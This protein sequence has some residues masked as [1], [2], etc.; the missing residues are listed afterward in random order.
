MKLLTP[1]DAHVIMGKLVRM[2]TGQSSVEVVDTSSFVSAGQL[3]LETGMENVYNNFN[4]LMGM[5][6]IATRKYN[7]DLTL[8]DSINSGVFTHRFEKVS[9]YSLDP[10]ASGN[11]NT[12]L[13]INLADGFTAGQNP[14]GHGDPQSTKSQWEQSQ[15]PFAVFNY[16]ISDVWDFCV[17]MYD[18]QVQQAFRNENEFNRFI[19]GYLTEHA[20]DIESQREAFNRMVLL[21]KIG[22][23]YDMSTSMPGSVVNLTKKY[24][25]KF[26]TSFTSAELRSTY[27]K[28]FL[29]FFLAELKSDMGYMKE[30][31]ASYHWSVPKTYRGVTHNI[32]RH[33]PLSDQRLYLFN[34]LFKDAETM[35]MPE[36]FNDEYLTLDQYQPITYWQDNSTEANRSKVKVAPAII[37]TDTSHTSTYGTQI[38]G[39]NVELDYVVG[40]LTDRDGLMTDF[41]IESARTTPIEARKGYRN[42]WLHVAK[43]GICDPTEKCILYIMADPS[44]SPTPTSAGV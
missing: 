24:N 9:Y 14:D 19:E 6:Y 31:S 39:E 8:M 15:R 32:L 44:P 26:G 22:Q 18:D 25:D 10:V 1:R 43:G 38:K 29:E 20:N 42:T 7:A 35:V 33:T 30:R 5:I 13:F 21:N 12:D 40:L 27:L 37:D 3:V 23:T 2:A 28:S 4:I 11:F 17:T 34:R 36:I 41:Q 16:G